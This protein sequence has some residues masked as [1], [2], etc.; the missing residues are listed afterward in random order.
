MLE[1]SLMNITLSFIL[2][3]I[4]F[5][6]IN[7]IKKINLFKD[8][9]ILSFS[10]TETVFIQYRFLSLKVIK[11]LLNYNLFR[12]II[13]LRL[14][15]ALSVLAGFTSN[16]VMIFLFIIQAFLHIRN[17]SLFNLADKYVLNILL[18]LSFFY[19]FNN[20]IIIQQSS[21]FFIGI[22]TIVAYTFTAVFK[23]MGESWR[24]GTALEQILSTDLY[25]NELYFNF[26]NKNKIM[27]KAINYFVIFF[28]LL[29]PLTILSSKFTIVYIIIGFFFHLSISVVMN[30][31][32]FFWVFVSTYPC[33]YFV[34]LKIEQYLN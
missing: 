3:Y 30:L 31:N 12:M 13:V 22:L 18:S 33:I 21:L 6:S 25:G 5:D 7:L 29:A 26:L 19:F 14:V 1:H 17:E 32:N 15:L 16:S 4:I 34:S 23:L 24:T 28:Q 11:F 2:I 9:E 20:S 27:S 10:P 8:K